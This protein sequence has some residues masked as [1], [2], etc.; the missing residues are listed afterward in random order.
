ML[1]NTRL[2]NNCLGIKLQN[3]ITCYNHTES[4]KDQDF[5]WT[6]GWEYNTKWQ[7]SW[8]EFL[9]IDKNPKFP[10]GFLY[11]PIEIYFYKV[12]H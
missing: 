7:H 4:K 1:R 12:V 2:K 6:N 8:I 9:C 3:E 5:Y 11:V 10:K